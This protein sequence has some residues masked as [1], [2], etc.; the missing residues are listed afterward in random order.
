MINHK[1]FIYLFCNKKKKKTIHKSA[2]RSTILEIWHELKTQKKPRYVKT[3][4]G[5]KR[6]EQNYELVLTFPKTRWVTTKTYIKDELGRNL[7]AKIDDN[8]KQRIKEIIPYWEEEHIYDFEN[9]KRIRYH[10]FL[11]ILEPVDEIC[12]L[13]KLNNK[14]ILQIE[15]RFRMFGNKNLSD[16][17]RLF[18]LIKEDLIIKKKGNF[19]FVRDITTHQRK[20]LYQMLELKGYKRNELFRHYSY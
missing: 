17:E 9:K 16:A 2:K 4:S 20:L 5:R 10:E 8:S 1:Y 15:D 13:F 6:T 11:E 7:E 3:L 12:Q 14:L 19:I 18:E